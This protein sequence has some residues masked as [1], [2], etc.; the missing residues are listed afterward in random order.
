MNIYN[1]FKGL[2]FE[3][4]CIGENCNIINITHDSKKVC[5][6]F[7]YI[8]LKGSVSDGHN[9]IG[10]AISKGAKLIICE[11]Y[12]ENFALDGI[13]V[14]KVKD[15]RIAYSKLAANFYENPQN[16]LKIV[17][18]VGT[19]GKSTTAHLLYSI[20]ANNGIKTGLLGTMYYLV[21]EDKYTSTMTTPDPM[22]LYSLFA[23]MVGK[24]VNVVVMEASAHAIY[25]KKLEDICFN[26]L[27]F[28]NLSQDHLDFFGNMKK[29]KECKQ[30]IFRK[31]QLNSAVINIDDNCGI[32]LIQKANYP[33]FTYSINSVSDYQAFE[34]KLNAQKS[35]FK[36][37][38]EGNEYIIN[39]KLLGKFNIYNILSAIISAKIIGLNMADIVKS[40]ERILPAEGRFNTLCYNGVNYIIDY[41]HTPDGLEKIITEVKG[42]SSGKVIVI[43]GCGGGRDKLKR[44]IMGNIASKL[45]DIVII[46]SDNPRNED[47]NK[48]IDDIQKGIVSP[49]KVF[50]TPNREH[51]IL[52]AVSIAK[53]QD[54]VIIAGKGA[55]E[56]IEEKG[57][58]I[59]YSDKAVLEKILGEDL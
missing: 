54:C 21:G 59:F 29:Y 39:T 47:K 16:S 35:T 1:L 8:C 24:G 53:A 9:Y 41:A 43:F 40:L 27:I 55:E 38:D 19:N 31:K 49:E 22:T 34:I 45:A 30:S 36:I 14:I 18:I 26:V 50:T 44:P 4:L 11:E 32:E 6:N 52:Y 15:T 48:I 20:L 10:E 12:N 51:A 5:L 13:H 17:G 2:E 58:K 46:T 33:Y 56:Y 42:F 25:L 23:K 28:T 3:V 57:K 37:L 7:A